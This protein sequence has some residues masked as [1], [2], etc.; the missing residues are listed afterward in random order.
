MYTKFVR[1]AGHV[2]RIFKMSGEELLLNSIKCPVKTPQ[3]SGKAQNVLAY[4]VF[5]FF[6]DNVWKR[7]NK[8]F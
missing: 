8:A 4:T 6:F 1:L 3:M 5:F 2:Q 7:L